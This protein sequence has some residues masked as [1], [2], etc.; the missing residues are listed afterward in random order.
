VLTQ[1]SPLVRHFWGPVRVCQRSLED[2]LLGQLEL[3]LQLLQLRCSLRS[4]QS[5]IDLFQLR[6]DLPR[7]PTL[8]KLRLRIL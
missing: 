1:R 3:A 6:P 4:R 8:L 5:L 7:V 2:L